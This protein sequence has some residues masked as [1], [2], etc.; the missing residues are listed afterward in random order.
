M[1]VITGTDYHAIAISYGNVKTRLAALSGYLY[2]AVYQVVL[3]NTYE[4]T[5]DLLDAFAGVY[6][7]NLGA[8]ASLIPF[9]PAVKAI[10][11]HVIN[12]GGYATV[13]AYLTAKGITVPQAWA[14]LCT[15]AGTTIDPSHI[16]G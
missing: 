16:S 5:K 15:A 1:A 4:P 11:S 13:N 6:E 9:V 12:R 10:N 8:Y 7:V 3:M 14:D 2:E